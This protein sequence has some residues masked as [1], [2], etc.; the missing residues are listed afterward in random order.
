M[1]D[2]FKEGHTMTPLAHKQDMN[3][4]NPLEKCIK[5][6]NRIPTFVWLIP[7]HCSN[8]RFFKIH[9]GSSKIV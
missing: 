4:Q 7:I 2:E 9:K 5:I 3:L 1:Y 6:S 8:V